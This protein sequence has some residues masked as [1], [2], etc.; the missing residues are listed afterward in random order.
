MPVFKDEANMFH[1]FHMSPVEVP[2]R[3]PFI[4]K[5]VLFNTWEGEEGQQR[6]GRESQKNKEEGEGELSQREG[7]EWGKR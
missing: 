4:Q 2:F 5:A 6:V 3:E 1:Y 7:E